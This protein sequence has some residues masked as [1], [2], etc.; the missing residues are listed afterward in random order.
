MNESEKSKGKPI[1]ISNNF[2]NHGLEGQYGQIIKPF[3]TLSFSNLFKT[4][5][6]RG[7][8]GKR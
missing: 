8:G 2:G 4:L 3:F 5:S 6:M 1:S 7:I